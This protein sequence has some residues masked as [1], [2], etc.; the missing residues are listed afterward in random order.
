MPAGEPAWQLLSDLKDI[1]DLVV[2]PAQTEES[3]AYLSFKITEHQVRFKEVFPDSDFLPKHHFLQHYPQLICE[4]GT[5][6][7]LWTIRFESKHSFFKRVVRH[8]GC[9]K[10]M[11]LS[12]AERY[13]FAVARQL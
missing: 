2:S 12:L 5:L 7:E 6:V 13:Q 11:L 4:F 1:V 10:N 9:F 8:T 3:I